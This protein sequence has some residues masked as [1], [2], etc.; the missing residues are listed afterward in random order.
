MCKKFIQ[1]LLGGGKA[2]K[3]PAVSRSGGDEGGAALI[4]APEVESM[5]SDPSAGRVRLGGGRRARGVG[6]AGLSI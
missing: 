4:L 6:V 1:G 2:P 5:S 3:P